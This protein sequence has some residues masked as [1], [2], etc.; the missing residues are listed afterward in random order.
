MINQKM[1]KFHLARTEDVNGV[2]GVGVVAEG[3]E[4][5][6]GMCALTWFSPYPCVNVYANAKVVV[7]VHSHE[8][9]TNLV[10]DE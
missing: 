4:F 3:V 5:T 7:Q 2:S 6:N 8:G 1:R 9:R 10:W